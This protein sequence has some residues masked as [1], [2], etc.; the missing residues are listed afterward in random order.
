MTARFDDLPLILET[1]DET[2][3]EAEIKN[4]YEL[5]KLPAATRLPLKNFISPWNLFIHHS[6][7]GAIIPSVY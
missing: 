6:P 3:Y 1:P 5:V 7:K 2:L 4:L